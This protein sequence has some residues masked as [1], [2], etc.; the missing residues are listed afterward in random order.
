MKPVELLQRNKFLIGVAVLVLA[1]LAG[2]IGLYLPIHKANAASVSGLETKAN[3]LD[4]YSKSQVYSESAVQEAQ[5]L[6]QDYQAG[7]EKVSAYLAKQSEPLEAPLTGPDNQP[8]TDGSTWKLDYGLA[9]EHLMDTVQK[10]FLVVADNPIVAKQYAT[11]IPDAQEMANQTRYLRVQQYAVDA[12]AGLNN[13]PNSHVVPVFNGFSFL[14]APERLLSPA[15]GKEFTPIPFEV[16]ISIEF[17]DIPRVLY[18]LLRSQ[19]QF[20]IT[21]VSIDRPERLD[22]S[23]Q[24]QI[25]LAERTARAKQPSQPELAAAPGRAAAGPGLSAPGGAPASAAEGEAAASAARE[26]AM[27]EA[28]RAMEAG[29]AAAAAGAARGREMGAAIAARMAASMGGRMG[30]R[31]PVGQPVTRGPA[32]SSSATMLTSKGKAATEE[33]KAQLP[34]TLVDVTIR[35]YVAAYKSPAPTTTAAAKTTG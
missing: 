20:D 30:M 24:N 19:V 31:G 28:A 13:P 32:R 17:T 21:S 16:R 12:I 6:T 7:L 29:M 26:A 5:K 9:V 14:A 11:E 33:E 8:A 27:A 2:I 22:R 10:S 4:K 15:H 3:S 23:G 1:G 18:A 35:G 34:K 25:G